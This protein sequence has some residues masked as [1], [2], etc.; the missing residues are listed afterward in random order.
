MSKNEKNKLSNVVNNVKYEV[1]AKFLEAETGIPSKLSKPLLEK[2]DNKSQKLRKGFL[3]FCIIVSLMLVILF[4]T[5]IAIVFEDDESAMVQISQR[6]IAEEWELELEGQL[7]EGIEQGDEMYMKAQMIYKALEEDPSLISKLS[8]QLPSGVASVLP[9][10]WTA[11][12]LLEVYI[13]FNE[14][15]NNV[16]VVDNAKFSL[17][18]LFGTFAMESGFG[19]RYYSTDGELNFFTAIEYKEESG[20][21]KGPFQMHPDYF[22]G[23]YHYYISKYENP[24]LEDSQRLGKYDSGVGN[25]LELYAARRQNRSDRCYFFADMVAWTVSHWADAIAGKN[26]VAGSVISG[27]CL[28]EEKQQQIIYDFIADAKHRGASF[29]AINLSKDTINES[30]KLINP[31]A[32]YGVALAVAVAKDNLLDPLLG[33]DIGNGR[34]PIAGINTDS[35]G[36][37]PG[38]IVAKVAQSTDTC[39]F[40]SAWQSK[41]Y[42]TPWSENN[43]ELHVSALIR[44]AKGRQCT[45]QAETL[46]DSWFNELGLTLGSMVVPGT[47]DETCGVAQGIYMYGGSQ[48]TLE[49]ILE[50]K[51]LLT[52]S[53]IMELR[54]DF[55]TAGYHDG[56]GNPTKESTAAWQASSKWGVPFYSQLAP[57]KCSCQNKYYRDDKAGTVVKN[58]GEN[59][60]HLYMSAYMASAFTGRLINPAEITA[61]YISMGAVNNAGEYVWANADVANRG[62]GFSSKYH[63]ERFKSEWWTITDNTLAMNGLVG[64]WVGNGGVG[65]TNGHHYIV[66]T[67]KVK[68]N[69]YKIFSSSDFGDCTTVWSKTELQTA[70]EAMGVRAGFIPAV[71]GSYKL[72]G[73]TWVPD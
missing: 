38:Q 2:A 41:S 17:D 5:A 69:Y 27:Y 16:N 49:Q 52:N 26:T 21:Y 61:Y 42:S 56:C 14:V 55:G 12:N 68:D 15:M 54:K 11:K 59:G 63:K 10:D 13:L 70:W 18:L 62:L 40:G 67:E 37:Y 32:N 6:D 65:I 24:D 3:A 39:N 25:N 58:I 57:S 29:A 8:F 19:N 53:Q 4:A 72:E 51:N 60:C 30:G 50:A 20:V 43:P 73:T 1:G 23:D 48:M 47:F 33:Y 28:E 31:A 66:I 64:A 7:P 36:S 45:L 44:I 9:N 46:I 71:K 22:S 34:Y 35:K